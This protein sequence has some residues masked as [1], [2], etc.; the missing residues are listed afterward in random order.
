M[1]FG[2]KNRS[3]EIKMIA[4]EETMNMQW[5]NKKSEKKKRIQNRSF[6]EK[7]DTSQMF[8]LWQRKQKNERVFMEFGDKNWNFL[9]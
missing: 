6:L 2:D 9:R 1:E 7:W 8:N 4:L 3:F 5:K